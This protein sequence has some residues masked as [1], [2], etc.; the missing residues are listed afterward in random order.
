M[1]FWIYHFYGLFIYLLHEEVMSVGLYA[2]EKKKKN[3]IVCYSYQLLYIYIEEI[4][5]KKMKT[6]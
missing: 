2:R 5:Q 1:I 4:S 3:L 6:M